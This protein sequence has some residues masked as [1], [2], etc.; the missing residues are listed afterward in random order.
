MMKHEFFQEGNFALNFLEILKQTI[1]KETVLN[2]LLKCLAAQKDKTMNNHN[3]DG[4]DKSKDKKKKENKDH[5]KKKVSEMKKKGKYLPKQNSHPSF[6]A[7]TVSS[8]NLSENRQTGDDSHRKKSNADI[9]CKHKKST[10]VVKSNSTDNNLD[11]SIFAKES[12]L[13]K[14]KSP[15]DLDL[16]HKFC[17]NERSETKLSLRTP[18]E[19]S[20]NIPGKN[21]PELN[22]SGN[23]NR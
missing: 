10:M 2:P 7:A 3:A 15:R 12:S 5:I 20:I 8:N 19:V 6:H 21:L 13:L 9:D 18:L 22:C 11:N 23:G 1:Q 17:E 16:L 14:S 4:R